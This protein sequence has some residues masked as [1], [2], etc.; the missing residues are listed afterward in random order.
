M[1]DTSIFDAMEGDL[2]LI[3]AVSHRKKKRPQTRTKWVHEILKKTIDIWVISPASPRAETGWNK[4]P[5]YFR[6]SP[7]EFEFLCLLSYTTYVPPADQPQVLL[8]YVDNRQAQFLANVL[9]IS[10]WPT[11]VFAELPHIY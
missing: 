5:N 4:V 3:A 8:P 11:S 1:M 9:L 2:L 7:T 6:V 10:S